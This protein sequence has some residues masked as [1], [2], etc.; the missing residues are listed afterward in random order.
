[1]ICNGIRL[2]LIMRY[3]FMVLIILRVM[4]VP[5]IQ[6]SLLILDKLMIYISKLAFSSSYC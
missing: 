2:V 4:N 5:Y 1:M 6:V 3:M